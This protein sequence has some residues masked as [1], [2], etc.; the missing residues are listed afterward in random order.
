VQKL[1]TAQNNNLSSTVEALKQELIGSHEEAE[2]ASNE[3]A[4]VRARAFREI[5]QENIQQEHE[6]REAESKLE[7]CRL[8]R[9]EWEQMASC[10]Y[11]DVQARQWLEPEREAQCMMPESLNLSTRSHAQHPGP[12]SS[13]KRQA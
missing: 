11:G 9:D 5:V 12:I 2:C 1:T 4:A 8:E 3:L 10:S 7:H 6:L 13:A